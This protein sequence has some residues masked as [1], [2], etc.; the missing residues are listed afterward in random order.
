M[1]NFTARTGQRFSISILVYGVFKAVLH[2]AIFHATCVAT[3]KSALL[4]LHKQSVTPCNVSCN[5]PLGTRLRLKAYFY[6]LIAQNIARQVARGVL[7]CAMLQKSVAALPQSLRK[8]ELYSTSC[9][10]C[11]NK[12][13]CGIWWFRGML[14]NAISRATCVA[15]KLRDKLHERLHI[16]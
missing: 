16:V 4:Q 10:A 12:K 15:T 6:W 1:R 14:H 8:V 5:F 13:Y 7:H 9:N 11:C 3:A 2:Y